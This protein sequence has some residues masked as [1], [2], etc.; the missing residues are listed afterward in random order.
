MYQLQSLSCSAV[1][2]CCSFFVKHVKTNRLPGGGGTIGTP[3]TAQSETPTT[4]PPT[5]MQSTSPPHNT[6]ASNGHAKGCFKRGAFP[7]KFGS[8]NSEATVPNSKFR[9]FPLGGWGARSR[10]PVFFWF[11][12]NGNQS[13]RL[14][15]P[16]PQQH[17]AG[18][19]FK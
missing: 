7:S 11:Q 16:K 10:H 13:L 12:E 8:K 4:L 14:K 9:I 6:G 3:E 18:P 5:H 2:N 19:W 1:Q 15:R 17:V